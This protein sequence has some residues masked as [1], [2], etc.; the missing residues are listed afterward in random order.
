MQS[1]ARESGGSTAIPVL[2]QKKFGASG[3]SLLILNVRYLL[4]AIINKYYLN[5][6]AN[7]CLVVYVGHVYILTH[8][9][10]RTTL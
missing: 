10:L 7:I 8:L 2:E 6:R 9:V 4:Y 3:S 5:N 1:G